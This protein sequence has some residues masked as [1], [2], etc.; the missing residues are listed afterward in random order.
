MKA[1]ANHADI[2]DFLVEKIRKGARNKSGKFR[3]LWGHYPTNVVTV[4]T[5]NKPMRN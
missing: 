2:K 4:I 1:K 5:R 3:H